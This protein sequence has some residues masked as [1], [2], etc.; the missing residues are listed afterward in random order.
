MVA[1]KINSSGGKV[2]VFIGGDRSKFNGAAKQNCAIAQK[3]QINMIDLNDVASAT[4]TVQRSD[5]II[6]AI[7]GTGLDREVKGI[8]RDVIDMINRSRKTVFSIDIPSGIHGNTGKIMGTAVKAH[9]TIT[10]GLPKIGN[11]L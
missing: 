9:Y 5:A 4:E 1:R 11:I 7:F 3:L 10:F 8:Y 2:T 6:D